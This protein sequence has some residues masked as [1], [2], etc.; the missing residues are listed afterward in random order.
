MSI[1]AMRISDSF[2][3]GVIVLSSIHLWSQQDKQQRGGAGGE[4]SGPFRTPE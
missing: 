3:L 1:G 2:W 4:R